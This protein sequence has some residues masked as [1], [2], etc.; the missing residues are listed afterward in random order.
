FDSH[1]QEMEEVEGGAAHPA[2]P[3]QRQR[4]RQRRH[5]GQAGAE[6]ARGGRRGAVE[7]AGSGGAAPP[8]AAG[9]Q[10]ARGDARRGRRRRGAVRAPGP[11][12]AALGRPRH[13]ARKVRRRPTGAARAR[14]PPAPLAL[15]LL[16]APGAGGGHCAEAHQRQLAQQAVAWAGGGAGSSARAGGGAAARAAAQPH[17]EPRH[18]GAE[19]DASRRQAA[20]ELRHGPRRRGPR[21]RRRAATARRVRRRVL[22]AARRAPRGARLAGR[23]RAWPAG[24]GRPGPPGLSHGPRRL[25][26]PPVPLRLSSLPRLLCVGVLWRRRCRTAPRLSRCCAS[27]ACGPDLARVKGR[28]PGPTS[29]AHW[30]GARAS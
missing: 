20:A 16:P 2:V 9:P 4:Y 25:C 8:G 5:L 30:S 19:R 12:K 11:R 6:C 29:Q 14:E 15:V 24:R 1:R 23:G 26:R 7:G 3:P 10:P 22:P 28:A 17:P 18:T 21:R 27:P 13:A